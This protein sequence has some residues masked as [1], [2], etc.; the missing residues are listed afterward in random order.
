MNEEQKNK[1]KKELK[2]LGIKLLGM[3]ICLIIMLVGCFIIFKMF[4]GVTE[5]A[6]NDMINEVTATTENK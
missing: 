3:I 6:V 2:R 1:A 5:K 4:V